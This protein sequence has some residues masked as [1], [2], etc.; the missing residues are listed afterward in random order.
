MEGLIREMGEPAR[1]LSIPPPPEGPPDEAEMGRLMAIA[2]KYGGRCWGPAESVGPLR[3]RGEGPGLPR[4]A[5]PSCYPYSPE[6][7]D[8]GFFN[9]LGQGAKSRVLAQRGCAVI[10]MPWRGRKVAIATVSTG[11]PGTRWS[12]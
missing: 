3:Q 7:V 12:P 5:R 9:T 11:R 6:C 2:A 10:H 8:K 4:G 1:S